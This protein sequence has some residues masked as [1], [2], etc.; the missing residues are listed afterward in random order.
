LPWYW[1]S[2]RYYDP[3]LRRFLQPDPSALDGVRSYVYCHNDP[4]D[5]SD[6]TGLAGGL[7][8]GGD[9]IDGPVGQMRFD[10]QG[11]IVTPGNTA[12]IASVRS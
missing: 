1:L 5:C 11:Q 2:V 10:E 7:G 6:P 8:E 12:P 9:R 4:A 3:S